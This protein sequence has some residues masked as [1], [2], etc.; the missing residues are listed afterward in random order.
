M[1]LPLDDNTADQASRDSLTWK[2]LRLLSFYRLI[3][4][5][6][7]TILFFGLPESPYGAANPPLYRLA[8][9]TVCRVLLQ[10]AVAVLV[11]L[12]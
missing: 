2:P 9:I 6:L 3:L 8:C 12:S 7:L 4:A 5:G 10:L 11:F 1:A